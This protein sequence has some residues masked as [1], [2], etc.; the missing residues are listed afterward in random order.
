MRNRC[1]L[2]IFLIFPS[3]IVLAQPFL[4][5]GRLISNN[6]EANTKVYLLNISNLELFFSGGRLNVVDS[7]TVDAN[8]NF[9][10]TNAA[11]IENNTFYRVNV[12]DTTKQRPGGINM[13]GTSE[14]FAFFLLNKHSQIEFITASECV[15]QKMKLIKADKTNYL[16][17]K[18]SAVR[19][20]YSEI[21]DELVKRRNAL[22]PSSPSYNDSVKQIR[23][24][25]DEGAIATNYYENVKTFADT[26]SVSY[27]SLLAMQFIGPELYPSFFSKMNERYKKSIGGSKY[28]KQ[29]NA[30]VTGAGNALKNGS[31]APNIILPDNNGKVVSLAD[32]KGRYVLIDF[33]ASWCTPCRRENVLYIKPLYDKYKSKGFTV[34]SVSQDIKRVAWLEAMKKDGMGAWHNLSDLKGPSSLAAKDYNITALPTSYLLDRNG[35]IIAKDLRGLALEDFMKKLFDGDGM[36]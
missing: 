21:V 28:A 10:F 16:I 12:V 24:R 30:T 2:S 34:M 9:Q 19:K 6:S 36:H 25:M 1:L 33:W 18:I 22:D 26:V 11:V 14:N 13:V 20:G 35:V 7:S 17:S 5:R 15:S 32:L 3:Y 4:L 27:A 31:K 8:G 29:F 23:I